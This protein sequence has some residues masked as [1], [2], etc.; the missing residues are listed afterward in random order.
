MP[1][2]IFLN[3]DAAELEA[4][5][6]NR[7]AV[8]EC[9]TYFDTWTE[10]SKAYR[11][12]ARCRLDV[13]YGD[14]EREKLDIFL[15]ESG[16]GPLHVFIH[17]GYWRTLDKSFFSYLAEPLTASGA[18]AA[19][20]NYPLCP[21]AKLAEIVASAR[22]AM[23]WLYREAATLGADR[24]QV[25]ISGH[26][27]GGHLVAMLMATRWPTLGEGLPPGMIRS[28]VA[29]SGVYDLAPLLHVSVNNDLQ[30]V[31]ADIAALS[32]VLL[33]PV[34]DAP[35]TVVDGGAELAEFVRQSRD[36]SDTWRKH[37]LRIDYLELPGLNHFSIVD[38]MD[39]P[40]DPIARRLLD[41]MSLS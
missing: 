2:N 37:G 33:A 29:I 26:S 35:L 8:P 1:G 14:H 40:D 28:G 10:R 27:A 23:T 17:G 4:Q 12:R 32:P 31:P 19:L 21:A 13:P 16:G 9:A 22:K 5:Y 41:H 15:P 7:R 36:F 11:A 20:I 18:T 24:D 39:R 6:D 25:H 34:G 38:G 30:L 3:Y